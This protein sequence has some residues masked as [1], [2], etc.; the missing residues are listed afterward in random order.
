[1]TGFARSMLPA[2]LFLL[3][4]PVSTVSAAGE[5]AARVE[6]AAE[7]LEKIQSIPES[8]VPPALLADAHGIAIIPGVI[9]VGLVVGGQYG[10]GV[11]SIRK[12]GGRWS[13][14]VF[15]N[16]ASGSIGWQ[17]GAES[18]DFVL[19]FKTARSVEGILRGKYTLGADA[20]V[21]AGPVG[22]SAKAATD[23][24]MKAEIFA[25]SRSRGLFAG[26]SLAGSSM[27]VDRESN[28]AFYGGGGARPADIVE[29]GGVKAPAVAEKLRTALETRIR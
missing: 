4:T 21:A 20:S 24:E 29:G 5:E 14:P 11:L 13:N 22:R 9:K 8:A 7:V 16:L 3:V 28:E 19:V 23:I 17:I 10:R 26:V 1:M 15:V 12:D 25:Y 2:L 6:A 18:A 27:Q